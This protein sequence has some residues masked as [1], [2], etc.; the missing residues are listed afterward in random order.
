[1]VEIVVKLAAC[2]TLR[3]LTA[4]CIRERRLLV[5]RRRACEPPKVRLADYAAA[6]WRRLLLIEDFGGLAVHEL[7]V[8]LY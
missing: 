5:G 3:W 7:G 4:N 6:A 2:Y 8:F 1:M